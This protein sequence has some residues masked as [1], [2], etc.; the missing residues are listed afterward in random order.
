VLTG[1]CLPLSQGLPFLP[2]VDVLREVGELD[3][4]RLVKA[5]L[6]ECAAFVRVRLSG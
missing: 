1:W 6:A 2:V 5:A 4:T 3:D